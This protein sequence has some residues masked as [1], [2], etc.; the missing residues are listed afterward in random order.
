MSDLLAAAT[1]E[2]VT[3]G[4]R[5][6]RKPPR[7]VES[8]ENG[9]E[10]GP[11][12][13][14]G[15]TTANFPAFEAENVED[16]DEDASDAGSATDEVDL[17]NYTMKDFKGAPVGHSSS[18]DRIVSKQAGVYGNSTKDCVSPRSKLSSLI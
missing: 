17:K 3:N 9:D 11:S 12:R 14:T 18:V 5:T 15:N 6:K 2:P 13:Q 1:Q 8:P 16:N 10:P 7:V 4:S